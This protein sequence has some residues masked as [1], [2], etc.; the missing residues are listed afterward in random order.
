MRMLIDGKNA[1]KA[2]FHV[3][4]KL[5]TSTGLQT[6]LA[7]NLL[8]QVQRLARV[9][10]ADGRPFTEIYFLWENHTCWRHDFYADYKGNRTYDD[11]EIK[12][13]EPDWRQQL[14]VLFSVLKS[15]PVTIAIGK[16]LEADDLAYLL[17][18]PGGNVM[19]SNDYDYLQNVDH[20]TSVY[21]SK[22][23]REI[24]LQN[25]TAETGYKNPA[26]LIEMFSICGDSGDGIPGVVGVGEKTAM[27]FLRGE[28]KSTSQAHIN[29]S[30]WMLDPN[31]YERSKTM[32]DMSRIPEEVRNSYTIEHHTL[33]E[34]QFRMH[35]SH[36]EWTSVANKYED[37]IAPFR[38]VSKAGS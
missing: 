6:G 26:E 38:Y 33:D 2:A 13:G 23:K 28:T 36:L 8:Q 11:R 16:K 15:L 4:G 9:C 18:S 1:T 7:T 24:T 5:K 29:I 37:W 17:K 10:A 32:F 20:N 22:N 12:P 14:G 34:D 3:N 25:F 19:L 21:Q 35:V 27:K 30:K 31:G